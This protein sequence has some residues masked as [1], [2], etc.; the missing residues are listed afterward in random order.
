[1]MI[2]DEY[3]DPFEDELQKY[4][5]QDAKVSAYLH[6][7][8]HFASLYGA[9]PQ[10]HPDIPE[11]LY[12]KVPKF[13]VTKW[14]P[15][16]HLS[17]E[18][19]PYPGLSVIQEENWHTGSLFTS[20]HA[21]TPN[22]SFNVTSVHPDVIQLFTGSSPTP[23]KKKALSRAEKYPETTVTTVRVPNKGQAWCVGPC[24]QILTICTAAIN[25][26]PHEVEYV[27]DPF[28][29]AT[30]GEVVLGYWCPPCYV[31]RAGE[32]TAPKPKPKIL[33]PSHYFNTYEPY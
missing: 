2:Y 23:A 4:A 24:K 31:K 22:I 30:K 19:K 16:A 26:S 15:A 25:E 5:E 27:A 3:G 28:L 11:F 20:N 12:E 6:K 17:P 18:T 21:P 9:G 14:S 1:M 7:S 8:Q 32:N 33:P 13:P 29:Q 10:K